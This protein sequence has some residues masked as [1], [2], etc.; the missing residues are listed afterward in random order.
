MKT[1]RFDIHQHVTDKIVTAIERG[2]GEFRLPWH[3]S[4]GNILRPANVASKKTYRGVN[5]LALWVTGDEKGFCSG[6]WGTYRQ[7]AEIGAQVRKGEKAA[8]IVF[9]KEITIVGDAGE[10]NEIDT[11]LF[12]RATASSSA[13]AWR[14]HRHARARHDSGRAR[15]AMHKRRFHFSPA[16]SSVLRTNAFEFIYALDEETRQSIYPLRNLP[17]AVPGIHLL[18]GEARNSSRPSDS[19]SP[20][21]AR[22]STEAMARRLVARRSSASIWR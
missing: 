9:Y 1:D 18:V 11:R 20:S 19:I 3:R 8:Y 5:I 21:I 12:A 22:V 14:Y 10:S 6:V 13:S 7:W 16:L 4:A 2:T 15:A 17:R